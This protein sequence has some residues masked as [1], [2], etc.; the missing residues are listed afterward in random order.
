MLLP[1]LQTDSSAASEVL[2]KH[3]IDSV[4]PVRKPLVTL[5][6]RTVKA[7]VPQMAC[8]ALAEVTVQAHVLPPFTSCSV[9]PSHWPPPVA[10]QLQACAPLRTIVLAVAAA[11]TASQLP[12][13]SAHVPCSPL[14]SRSL[15]LRPLTLPCTCSG[16]LPCLPALVCI[17]LLTPPPGQE[18]GLLTAASLHP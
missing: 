14:F 8:R 18:S 6:F 15:P 3:G 1:Q 13:P 17:A 5:L 16:P 7:T 11:W 2:L 10:Q 9:R 4:F 12:S